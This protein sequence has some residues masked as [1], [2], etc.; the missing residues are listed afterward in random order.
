[1]LRKI[2][3]LAGILITASS[4]ATLIQMDVMATPVSPGHWTMGGPAPSQVST[5]VWFDT[6]VAS[7]NFLTQ[8]DQ[9]GVGCISQFS[10][11]MGGRIIDASADGIS[12]LQD[13]RGATDVGGQHPSASCSADQQSFFSSLSIDSG[14]TSLLLSLDSFHD[15]ALADLLAS[16]D[17]IGQLLL[18]LSGTRN[19]FMNIVTPGGVAGGVFA[20]SGLRFQRVG[21]PA[22]LGLFA[23]TLAA[24]LLLARRRVA[25]SASVHL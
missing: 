4:H 20:S 13:R 3:C 11:N 24:A 12:F 19:G 6:A 16:T 1:M 17:P 5:H 25:G 7:H 2:L 14:D 23:I 18:A 22:S 21:E 8:V 9:S 10:A 15:I